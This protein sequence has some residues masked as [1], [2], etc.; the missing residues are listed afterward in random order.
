MKFRPIFIMG[1]SSGV[2]KTTIVTALCK[3]F[4]DM[5]LNVV[6][7]KAQNMSLN[8]GVGI[9][10]EM[11]YAQIIQAIGCGK[12]PN[13]KMNP[14]LLKPEENRTQVIVEG[15]Y[16]GT[17]DASNY[18]NWDK[19][20][21]FNKVIK[22]FNI[23]NEENDLVIVEGAGSPAEINLRYD[24]ANM[25]LAEKINSKNI[26]VADIDKGGAF[27]SIVGTVDIIGKEKFSGYILNKFRGDVSLLKE[28]YDFL[29]EKYG[30]K[31]YG[32]IPYMNFNLPQEDSLWS[33]TGKEGKI[34][35]SIIK[36]PHIS[37]LTDFHIFYYIE[38]IGVNFS[39][40]PEDLKNSDIIII[41][42]TKLTVSDMLYL[43]NE[44][45]EDAI[46]ENY[47]EGKRIIGICGG[48]QMLG[49]Y[50]IDNFE[51]KIGKIPGFGILKSR[52][53]FDNKKIVSLIKG[54]I[55]HPQFKNYRISGYEIHFGKSFSKKPFSII[56]NKNG[57]ETYQFDGSFEKNVIGTYF[58]DI[59][60]NIKFLEKYL[61][62][63]L[64]EYGME[65]IKINYSLNKEIN[66]LAKFIKKY[67][68]VNS[69]LY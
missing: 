8:S 62:D 5:G 59:F 61:N 9:G 35:I 66:N 64:Q 7:F 41:P 4:S 46:I 28:G 54:E 39:K 68:D 15:K 69:I 63:I 42:G 22:N 60:L 2:G 3:I 50:I 48:Y 47:R 6:P 29:Y 38:N 57:F 55:V 51:T 36:L 14:V 30:L 25:K 11:A 37:N 49:E 26:L 56:Y 43:K 19:N 13:V 32:T 18:M 44:G 16:F 40:K 34:K 52:T 21:I 31:H 65:K 20:E 58:H 12:T 67:I 33:W 53:K 24:I 17:L 10:G 45:F 27:A 23:L 1:T